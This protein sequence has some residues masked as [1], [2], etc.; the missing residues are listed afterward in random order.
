MIPVDF[1][2]SPAWGIATVCE[3][4]HM[5]QVGRVRVDQCAA[6]RENCEVLKLVSLINAGLFFIQNICLKGLNW[7]RCLSEN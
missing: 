6:A 7:H 3:P 1:I 5:S 4:G 2:K